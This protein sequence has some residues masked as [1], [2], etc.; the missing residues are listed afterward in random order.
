MAHTCH[1]TD[2]EVPIP[3]KMFMC[4]RHWFMLPYRLRNRLLAAYRPGQEDDKRPS[5]EYCQ[6]A[7][8]CLKIIAAEEDLEPDLAL[9]EMFDP[10]PGK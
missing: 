9:Y 10:G 7:M 4:Q 5:H 3:A 2:C 1:A 6:V 8:E